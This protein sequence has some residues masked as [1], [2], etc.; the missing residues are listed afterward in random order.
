MTA[1]KLAA[2]RV[3]EELEQ[4]DALVRR[5]AGAAIITI[6]ERAQ[7]GV[8]QILAARWRNERRAAENILDY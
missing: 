3:P 5:G 1:P 2:D 8:E 4:L 6:D 7:V